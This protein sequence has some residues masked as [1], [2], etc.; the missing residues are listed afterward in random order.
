MSKP[1]KPGTSTPKSGQYAVVGPRGGDKGREVTSTKGNPLPP[2]QK[3]GD[4]YK[5]VDPTKH[6]K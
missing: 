1:L 6:K 3:P 5:L 2:T 4:G